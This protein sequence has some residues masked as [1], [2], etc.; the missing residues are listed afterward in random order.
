MAKENERIGQEPKKTI[1]L[2]KHVAMI[3]SSNRLS[4]LQRKIANA[5]LFNA[6]KDLMDKDEY[7]IHVATLCKLIGY[8]SNDYKTIKKSLVNLLSTVL[9]WNLIDGEK[10]D[11]EGVWNASS[12]IADASIDGPI[13]TYSYSNKMRK[14]LHRPTI[15]G[16]LDMMVQAKFQSS[17]G[18]ALYEN[19]NRYQ[20]IGQSPWFDIE[21]F[22][23]LMGVVDGKYKIFRD[24]KSRVLDKAVEEVNAYSSITVEPQL[25]RLKQKVVAIQFLIKKTNA[26][27]RLTNGIDQ[28]EL[29]DVL[30]LHFGLS[31][32]QVVDVLE[33]YGNDYIREKVSLIEMSPSFQTGKINNL[34][35]YL[36]TALKD[37]YQAPK[38]GKGEETN[39]KRQSSV[40]KQKSS[41]NVLDFS[42]PVSV[43][44]GELEE[45]YNR[46]VQTEL[47]SII[48]S[49]S[50]QDIGI[51]TK[52]FE[53]YLSK[54]M[55]GIY[56]DV[57]LRDGIYHPLIQNHLILFVRRDKQE[58][59][60]KVTSY[61]EWMTQDQATKV[62]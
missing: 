47:L 25:R 9:E 49:M 21:K 30:K 4:L 17:Y 57:Y 3:H 6:Y 45:Q 39:A 14:L 11:S 59:M 12:I 52:E 56:H 28:P 55:R 34:A 42:D 50:K 60:T 18:L 51:L 1:E 10:V 54:S 15:Y 20:N 16:R 27:A 32:R 24:F 46:Y 13:C 26:A 38:K 44:M 36:L 7:E 23:K 2:K 37:D 53:Q 61:D 40:R 62:G 31:K 19:C 41:Y 48:K 33:Q 43:K 5:L 22:R 35:K 58:V 29:R 8:D